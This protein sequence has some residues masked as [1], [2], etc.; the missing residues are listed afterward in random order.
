[1]SR[2]SVLANRRVLAGALVAGALVAVLVIGW[3]LAGDGYHRAAVTE[4]A[5]VDTGSRLL[6]DMLS[7]QTAAEGFVTTLDPSRQLAYQV[8]LRD[9]AADMPRARDA[10]AGV[11]GLQDRLRRLDALAAGWR[12]Q[13]VTAFQQ[14]LI[15]HTVVALRTLRGALDPFI[16]E[17]RGLMAALQ[18][19]RLTAVHDADRWS[20]V[21]LGVSIAAVVL[22]TLALALVAGRRPPR[23]LR[24]V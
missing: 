10:G 5:R 15:A 18:S 6:P 13:V 3:R 8:A 1:M 23:R 14:A 21:V 17:H 12:R 24:E 20:D 19:R 2:L 16:R 4:V 11:A 9:Y 22:G 7:A